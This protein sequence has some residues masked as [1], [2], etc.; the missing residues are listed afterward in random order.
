MVKRYRT[1]HNMTSEN[2]SSGILTFCNSKLNYNSMRLTIY[3][4]GMDTK[5][6]GN[7]IEF[8]GVVKLF[9]FRQL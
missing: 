5:G 7:I 9:L 3:A 2:N 1:S 6:L 4:G 8:Q